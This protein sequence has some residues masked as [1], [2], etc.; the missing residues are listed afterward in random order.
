MKK[1]CISLIIVY[2]YS[3]AHQ[4]SMVGTG[5]KSISGAGLGL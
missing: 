1:I 3:R 4:S 2:V 5:A